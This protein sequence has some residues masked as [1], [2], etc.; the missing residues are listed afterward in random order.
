MIQHQGWP[1]QHREAPPPHPTPAY[2]TE[3][4]VSPSRRQ[5][6]A[7]GS[8]LEE[9]AQGGNYEEEYMASQLLQK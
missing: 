9:K 4:Q 7:W 2:C 3:M 6:W 1:Q 5:V 8:R